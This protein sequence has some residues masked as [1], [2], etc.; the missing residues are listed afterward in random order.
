MSPMDVKSRRGPHSPGTGKPVS[1]ALAEPWCPTAFTA[2]S[3]L[4]VAPTGSFSWRPST[5][6][7]FLGTSDISGHVS[8]PRVTSAVAQFS[9]NVVGHWGGCI[10]GQLVPGTILP[11]ACHACLFIQQTP[12]ETRSAPGPS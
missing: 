8:V 6:P 7:P 10:L 2:F 9:G 1:G 5:W 3:G 4:P 11:T 12:T